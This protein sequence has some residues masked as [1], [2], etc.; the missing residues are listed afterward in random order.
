MAK[1]IR[2][3]R[4]FWGWNCCSETDEDHG[5]IRNLNSNP[6]SMRSTSTA[7]WTTSPSSLWVTHHQFEIR[8]LGVTGSI[9]AV[10]ACGCMGWGWQ[11]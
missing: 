11:E 9:A 4:K 1:P 10:P 8:D 2:S 7:P 5:P 6:N 3:A